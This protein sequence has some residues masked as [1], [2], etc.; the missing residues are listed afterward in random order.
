MKF[1]VVDTET[2]GGKPG[3]D[4]L[5]EIGIV[6][7]DDMQRVGE[8]QTLINPER[9]IPPFVQNLTG[10]SNKMVAEAPVFADVAKQVRESLADRIFVAHN[11][12]FDFGF[13]R[14]ELEMCGYP[15]SAPRL[16]TVRLTR[17]AF[18]GY[19]SYS[20]SKIATELGVSSWDHHRALGDASAAASLLQLSWDKIGEAGILA[21]TKGFAPPALLPQGWNSQRLAKIPALP[22]VLRI[23][24]S[25]GQLLYVTEA[26][27]LLEKTTELLSNPAKRGPLASIKKGVADLDYEV[28]GSLLLAKLLAFQE[29]LQKKPTCNRQIRI[30]IDTGA[31]LRDQVLVQPGRSV[32]ERAALV[33]KHGRLLGYA[34][35]DQDES[36][37]Q[38]ELEDRLEPLDLAGNLAP[39]LKQLRAAR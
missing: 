9:P 3:P 35:F 30:P 13:V 16:C 10:I 11:V 14:K 26:N 29:I 15:F 28:T 38:E 34:W 33:V 7:L 22:G 1:A 31:N 17:Q 23:L 20:L 39:L 24:G 6:L 32:N 4:R 5:T 21:Q 36:L 37:N 27:H 25:Q 12:A 18:P 8:F 2:T 19:A